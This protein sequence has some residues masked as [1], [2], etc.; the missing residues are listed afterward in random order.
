M[1]RSSRPTYAQ[2]AFAVHEVRLRTGEHMTV[3]V[4]TDGCLMRG[5]SARILIFERTTQGYRR[6]L[7][8]VT[9]PDASDVRDD[10]TVVLPTHD[11]LETIFEATYV[12]RGTTYVFS[13][14]QS[15]MYDVPLERRRPYQVPVR[16]ASGTF[17]T[18]LSGTFA[19]NFGQT[20][21]FWARAGQRVRLA[22]AE[23]V[24]GVRPVVLLTYGEHLL[25]DLGSKRWTGVLPKTGSY[26]LIV[27]GRNQPSLA[28]YGLRLEIR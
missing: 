22:M 6:V 2:K 28:P 8:E 5:Q 18:T 10:G 16:F 27:Y 4:A 13:P 21:V 25:A 1:R 3:A 15:H 17:A 7:D 24:P 23:C 26:E 19:E 11:T 14:L 9:M 12:W 20:Y